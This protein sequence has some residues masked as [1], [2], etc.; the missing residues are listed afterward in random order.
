MF[1]LEFLR[2][3]II[4]EFLDNIIILEFLYNIINSK[5]FAK[6]TETCRTIWISNYLDYY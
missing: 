2:N 6:N 3:I 4:S 1:I 5:S